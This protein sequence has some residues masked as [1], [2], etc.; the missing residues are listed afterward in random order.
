MPRLAVVAFDVNET[1]VDLEPLRER[2]QEVRAPG[3]LLES[4]FA[5]TL[6]DGIALTTAG[7]YA[8]FQTIARGGL[9]ALLTGMS[10]LDRAPDAASEYV[11]AGF[12][13]LPLHRDVADGMSV[14]RAADVRLV[15]L[16]NGSAELTEQLLE[17]GGVGELVER[18]FSVQKVGRWKPARE[19]YLH[20][21]RECGVPADGVALIAVHPWDIDGAKRAGLLA[22]WLNRPDTVYPDFFE[23]PDAAGPDLAALAQALLRLPGSEIGSRS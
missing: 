5:G 11:M 14:L 2:L 19:P 20:A 18:Q 7:A 17:R 9:T 4:W 13:E 1:L 15:T 16:T 23:Q 21:A 3:E 10:G 8:D 22:G 6:R 12:S